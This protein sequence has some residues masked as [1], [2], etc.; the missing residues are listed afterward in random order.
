MVSVHTYY[1][2]SSP[3]VA[4]VWFYSD[5][6]DTTK[7]VAEWK[8]VLICGLRK[9]GKT[10]FALN[11]T[12]TL[13]PQYLWEFPKPTDPATLA[14]VGQ[15]WSEP[16][17]GRVKIEVGGE[18]YERWVAFIGG[19]FDSTNSTGK[20][21]FV[22]DIKSGDIIKEFSGIEGM[23][24]S[25]AA[26][27][28]AVDTNLDGFIDKI[29]IG[30]LGGQMW[31]FDVSFNESSKKSNSQWTGRRLFTAPSSGYR[32]Y[33]QPAVAFD[34]YRT[35]WVNFGTGDREHPNDLSSPRERF[36][37]VKDNGVGNY[38]RSETDLSDLT[39]SNTFNPT[40]QAGWYIQL[41]KSTDRS[42]KVL[43][44]PVVFNRLVYFTTYT[45]ATA[46][47]PC[48]V[49]GEA[50]LYIVE[51][52]SAGGALEVDDLVDLEGSPSQQRSKTIGAGAPSTP[53][54]TVNVKG[55]ASVTIGTTSDQVLSTQI[56]SPSKSKEVLYWRE[57]IP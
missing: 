19:G 31:V 5:S 22:V 42:E 15:S 34:Q 40:S 57:V 18:L 32:I 4:D 27:P 24:Y 16:V 55:V 49:P 48:S 28:T 3:K 7:S 21:F 11:I 56:F 9:G 52:L 6:I 38:P 23:N 43:A 8:T 14:K 1:V 13:N 41:E 29:Y 12:D 25:F 37:A 33:Y 36:Y 53:V 10:Y 30:D 50:K 45:Y 17:I 39:S 20:A 54:I 35:P 2:D 47:N 44:K 51:Y 46:A 26:P